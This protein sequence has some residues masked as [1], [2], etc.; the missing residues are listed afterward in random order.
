MLSEPGAEL[1]RVA[2]QVIGAAIEVHRVIGPVFLEGVYEEALCHEL[3]LRK[4]RFSRQ[5]LIDLRYKGHPVGQGRLDVLVENKLILELKAV[6]A[7]A[8]VQQVQLHSYLKAT[9]LRLG[10]LINFNVPLLKNGIKR[11]IAK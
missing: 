11:I 6:E 10:L 3:M 9:N 2:N 8:T 5:H 7:L 1:D 4:M